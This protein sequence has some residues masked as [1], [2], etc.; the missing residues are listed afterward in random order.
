M[1]A[2]RREAEFAEFLSADHK[3]LISHVS[4]VDTETLRLVLNDGSDAVVRRSA[5]YSEP[6]Y[7]ARNGVHLFVLPSNYLPDA[8]TVHYLRSVLFAKPV[9]LLISDDE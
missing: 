5:D 6:P 2:Q 9:S 3:W 7:I 4:R 1:D 8:T